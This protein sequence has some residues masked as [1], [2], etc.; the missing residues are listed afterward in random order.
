MRLQTGAEYCCM[1]DMTCN[2]SNETGCDFQQW[3]DDN[4]AHQ[5]WSVCL[6]AVVWTFTWL[7]PTLPAGK[8]LH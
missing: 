5:A 6:S 1:M 3:L 2:K 7:Q 8:S 4:A